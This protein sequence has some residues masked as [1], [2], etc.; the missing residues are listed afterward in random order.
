MLMCFKVYG[1]VGKLYSLSSFQEKAYGV[2]AMHRGIKVFFHV[3]LLLKSFQSG[4]ALKKLL[5]KTAD[6]LL[7]GLL[8]SGCRENI[9]K[10]LRN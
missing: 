1:F 5:K 6:T 2:F 4:V 9:D 10:F 8:Q 7:T 3:Y